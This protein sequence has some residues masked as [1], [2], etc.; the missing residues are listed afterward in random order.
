MKKVKWYFC[1]ESDMVFDGFTDGERWNGWNKIYITKETYNKIT[2]LLYCDLG[3]DDEISERHYREQNL[4][5]GFYSLVG[6]T[7][8]IK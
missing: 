1:D 2:N 6:Y 5:N 8:L 7:T 3:C 4:V